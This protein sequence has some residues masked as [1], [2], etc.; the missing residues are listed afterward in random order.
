MKKFIV[1]F[2][3][4][5]TVLSCTDQN[6]K[7]IQD[8]KL[9]NELI[10]AKGGKY[11]GRTL[12]VNSSEPITA[13]FPASVTDIYSQHVASQ[14]YEGLLK[15]DPNDLTV[16]PAIASSFTIDSLNKKYR[17]KIR[18]GVY[19]HD[20]PCFKNGKGRMVTSK[21]VQYVFEFLCSNHKMNASPI[22]WRNSILGGN[23]YFEN[24]ADHVSG[25]KVIDEFTIEIELNEPF[26]GFLNILALVQTSIFPIEAFEKYGEKLM[27][28]AAV[29]TGP[30][31]VLTIKDSFKLQ[32]NNH[33]WR[34]DEFGNSLP[35]LSY[36]K[37]HFDLN[38]S[39]ELADFKKGDLDF[40]WGLPIEEIPNVI[41][42]LE[43]A[44]NGKNKEFTVQS[45][46]NLQVEYYAFLMN[47]TLLKNKNLRKAL[48]YAV[49][50][51]YIATYILEGS[52][53]PASNGIIPDIHG[54][55]K[56][57]VKGYEFSAKKAQQY[58][59]FA[60][61][62]NGNQLKGIKLY[63]NN[64]GQI[65]EL[66]ANSIQKQILN[67]LNINI[68]LIEYE[69]KELFDKIEAS[70][71]SFWRF[72]WIADYPDPANFIAS[73]HSKNINSASKS[74]NNFG[75]Y[76][77]PQFDEYFDQAMS[78]LN[79]TDRMNNLAMAEN[80]L[81]EDAAVLPL[82]YFTSIRLINPQ[83]RDFP[84]NELEYRDYSLVYFTKEKKK[85]VR[86]YESLVS[87]S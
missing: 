21:D 82:F 75:F 33:Y 20:D 63:Y 47:D 17:F 9:P 55:P 12:N 37:I 57:I 86:I 56:S 43:D 44:K 27:T 54:Y 83:L 40:I 59:K 6:K 85:R 52:A 68:E 3:L 80:I 45:I 14:I 30:F 42:S 66:V 10:P 26:S 18:E 41:G 67:T 87:E 25:I 60:G 72:G 34:K 36:V 71:L 74:A 77:N 50:K 4:V 58:L 70:A 28:E 53:L 78:A 79:D 1:Y 62:S 7:K 69:R 8:S 32:K 64:T 39:S 19:F 84:I 61:Y 15:F 65:N 13:L 11:Y 23:D 49:N 38:K 81:I 16:K 48:N 29:G 35:L 76:N 24:N 51:N 46:N 31:Q 22:Q 2:L 73:F 5:L